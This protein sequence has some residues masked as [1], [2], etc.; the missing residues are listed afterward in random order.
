MIR[1]IN[2][3]SEPYLIYGDETDNF[4]EFLKRVSLLLKR[5]KNIAL[6]IDNLSLLSNTC[7]ITTMIDDLIKFYDYAILNE[8][9]KGN[10]HIMIERIFILIWTWHNGMRIRYEK[11]T[12]EMFCHSYIYSWINVC[13]LISLK[14][15]NL[16]NMEPLM[17]KSISELPFIQEISTNE[18]VVLSDDIISSMPLITLCQNID[19]LYDSLISLFY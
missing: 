1:L 15:N 3:G 9:S 2:P 7:E 11:I 4:E 8:R 14:L 12:D 13:R 16:Y 18:H 19:I 6:P 5:S 10:T 17:N